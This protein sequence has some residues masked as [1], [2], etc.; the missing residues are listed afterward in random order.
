MVSNECALAVRVFDTRYFLELHEFSI[1]NSNLICVELR[2][3]GG[4]HRPTT[5]IRIHVRNGLTDTD[6]SHGEQ[7]KS[8][9]KPWIFIFIIHTFHCG[10]VT[11]LKPNGITLKRR[12]KMKRKNIWWKFERRI[13]NKQ[14]W[15]GNSLF[16]SYKT[17][18]RQTAGRSAG[19]RWYS[20]FQIYVFTLRDF[21]F[22]CLSA[23]C[24][25]IHFFPFGFCIFCSFSLFSFTHRI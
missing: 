18:D 23:I 3:S 10:R 19:L 15:N 25:V 4:T 16:I 5:M 9:A 12:H 14:E 1:N 7:I 21:F 13:E 22:F 6:T 24:S 2:L 8:K 11:Q 20:S 17:F